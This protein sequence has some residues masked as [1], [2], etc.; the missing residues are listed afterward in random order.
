MSFLGISYLEI[1]TVL[2]VAL[3]FLGPDKMI[4]VG[5]KLGKTLKDVRKMASELPS[6]EDIQ[7]PEASTTEID[8]TS[9]KSK[10][11]ENPPSD[12]DPANNRIEP[13]GP[14]AFQRAKDQSQPL[15]NIEEKPNTESN[16]DR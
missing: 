2:L 6:L 13:D 1:F 11:N 7:H 5:K 10:N 8:D 9:S 12:N 14:I 15:E 4:E 16:L 3:V